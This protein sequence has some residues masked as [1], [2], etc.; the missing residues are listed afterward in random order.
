MSSAGKR[1]GFLEILKDYWGVA[2]GVLGAVATIAAI[3]FPDIG[4]AIAYAALGA[5]ALFGLLGIWWNTALK[6]GLKSFLSAIVVVSALG[7]GY[8]VYWRY[9]TPRFEITALRT[10]K[11][12]PDAY[13]LTDMLIW[14]KNDLQ[15]YG[16]EI[17]FPIQIIPLYA[18]ERRLGKVIAVITG[19]GTEQ[20]ER[21]LW[22][23]YDRD[24]KTVEIA[25]TL[26]E[27]LDISGLQT[28]TTL[29]ANRFLADGVRYQRAHLDVHI[30]RASRPEQPLYTKRIVLRNAPWDVRADMVW[31]NNRY[32]V[33]V[34]LKNLG[35]QGAFTVLYHLV[36]FDQDL[37][38]GDSRA[39]HSGTDEIDYWSKPQELQEL[40]AGDHLTATVPMP[41]QLEP[42]RYLIEVYPIKR[43]NYVTFLDP[44]ARWEDIGT[45]ETEWWY[46]GPYRWLTFVVA[47]PG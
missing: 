35:G 8:L 31:R 21:E 16:V 37:D 11:G 12:D 34:F 23:H 18:S 15:Q 22:P 14:N 27:V 36:R 38:P 33:D 2:I 45:L 32:E 6:T 19:D 17:V 10:L 3:L 41:S 1:V 43:Q 9:W 39:L 4:P 25:L 29:P 46:G 28:N 24:V 44:Q 47:S 7:L 26:P 30:V 40:G 42:G 20:A 13:E 5:F